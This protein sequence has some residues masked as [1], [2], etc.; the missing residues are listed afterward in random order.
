[1]TELQTNR[2]DALLRR[3]GDLKGPGSK[4]A[5]V[6]TELFPIFDVENLPSELYILGGTDICFGGGILTPAA[7]EFAGLQIFNPIGSSKILTVTSLV[8]ASTANNTI[9]WGVSN[10]PLSNG[11]GTETFRDTRRTITARPSGQIRIE[12]DAA[13]VGNTGQTRVLANDPFTLH[14]KNGL[15]VLLPGIGFDLGSQIAA[16]PV[17]FTFYWRERVAEPS[18]LNL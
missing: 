6:L 3:V 1:V 10:N 18:E 16:A 12:S 17:H 15:A 11:I 2:Y 9:R 5:E 4:V 14:D 8:V 13:F 7:G